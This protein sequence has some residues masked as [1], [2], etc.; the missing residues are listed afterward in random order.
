MILGIPKEILENETR[1]AVIPA[2]VKQ[3]IS[4]GFDVKIET[5]AGLKSQITDND[6]K[7]AGAE[8]LSDASSVFSSSDMILKV[9]SPTDDELSMIK[10]GSSYI[11]FFQ[12]MK[13]CVC[14][15]SFLLYI[16]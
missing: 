1:V 16:L 12:T 13:D 3:Y 8:I 7:E 10:D 9:N 14:I 11:S 4:A 2:T 5:G 15:G 6:F